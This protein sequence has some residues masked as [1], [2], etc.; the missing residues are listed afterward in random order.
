M[1]GLR[2][3][4][5]QFLCGAL[6]ADGR[7]QQAPPDACG[8]GE[9]LEAGAVGAV[10]EV[11]GMLHPAE[12]FLRMGAAGGCQQ[13][14]ILKNESERMIH[15]HGCREAAQGL[16]PVAQPERAV[17]LS[18][19]YQ[20]SFCLKGQEKLTAPSLDRK[21]RIVGESFACT[22]CQSGRQ[23]DLRRRPRCPR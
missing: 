3:Q 22:S 23:P 6:R 1:L 16:L 12:T 14:G 9:A 20:E 17:V 5:P 19:K 8:V 13:G 2:D 21:S 11:D 15:A 7:W 4:G 10:H 18:A